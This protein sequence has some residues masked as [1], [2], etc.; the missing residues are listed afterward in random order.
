MCTDASAEGIIC[1]FRVK[2]GE[3]VLVQNHCRLLPVCIALR[4]RALA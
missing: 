2:D 3:R 1:N 4:G